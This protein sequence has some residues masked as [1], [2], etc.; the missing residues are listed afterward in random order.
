[1]DK[2]KYKTVAEYLSAQP[3]EK[4]DKL[5]ELIASIKEAAPGAE[6]VVSY[7]MPGF[8]L[9]GMIA[10]C[11]AHTDH[12][13]FYPTATPIVHFKKELDKYTTSKGAIQ[14]PVEKA[15]PASLVKKIVQ[16]KVK[17]LKD[18]ASSKKKS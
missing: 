13:G 10:W 17:E 6:E 1:M 11:A 2:K 18:K 16:W 8:K 12:I 9:N 15:I 4:R 5:K 14:F 7:N 3:K